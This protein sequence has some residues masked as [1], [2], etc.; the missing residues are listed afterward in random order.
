VAD[1]KEIAW[2]S[3]HKMYASG[4]STSERWRTFS[5]AA[6]FARPAGCAATNKPAQYGVEIGQAIFCPNG[7]SS[8]FGQNPVF[9]P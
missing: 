7:K 9:H 4:Y 8:P 5:N 6:L 3:I 2:M 1:V